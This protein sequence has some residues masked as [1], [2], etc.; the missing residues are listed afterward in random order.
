MARLPLWLAFV[1]VHACLTVLGVV[2]VPLEAFWDL[3]LYRSWAAG[4]LVAGQWPVL[5]T[6]WVYPAGALVPVLLPALVTTASTAGYALT[7]CGM[8]T[9][10]DAVALTVLLRSP[11]PAHRPT[12]AAWWWLAFLALLGPVAIGRL[13]AV[14][15][16]LMIVALA[17]VVR[18]PGRAATAA[19]LLTVGAWIKVAPGALLVP[20]IMAARRPWRD[21]VGVAATV[22]AVV[23]T[24]V[25]L[26]GGLA[27][28]TSFVTTQAE[29]GLQVESV[30]ATPWVVAALWRDDVVVRL[31]EELVTYEVE[32]PGTA[33]TADASDAVLALGVLLVAAA[34]LVARRRG[35]AGA[36]LLPAALTVVGVLFAAN[37]VGSP[38]LVAWFAAPVAVLLAMPGPLGRWRT[39]VAGLTLAAA[40]LTQVVFPWGYSSLLAGGP[41]VTAALAARNVALLAVLAVAVA[42][43]HR[44]ALS[45]T[46]LPGLPGDEDADPSTAPTQDRAYRPGSPGTT[47]RATRSRWS[48]SARSSTWR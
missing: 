45:G 1:A 39:A 25:G 3:D 23:L 40:A 24:A 10:L 19:T 37:K 14:I 8:V 43:L 35:T 13:D 30:A 47:S 6:P 12:R 21:V 7:W 26:G 20:V 32:G 4:A 27:R 38:Q 42:A 31:D 34:L 11:S 41:G 28:V 36:A 29:R 17:L 48:R 5:D 15:T 46:V 16:P 9:V 22:S 18:S 2:V 33:A 44:T